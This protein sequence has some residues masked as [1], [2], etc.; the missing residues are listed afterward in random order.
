MT[1]K[2]KD[3]LK[4]AV[5]NRFTL[6]GYLLFAATVAYDA[7]GG[8]SQEIDKHFGLEWAVYWLSFGLLSEALFGFETFKAYQKTKALIEKRGNIDPRF[9]SKY[10]TYC[11]RKGL[12]L[13]IKE[14]GLE[15]IVT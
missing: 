4:C 2:L 7:I 6:A 11:S 15:S 8:S 12:N 14:A 9:L 5:E 1:Q 13:A 3:Y 10:K